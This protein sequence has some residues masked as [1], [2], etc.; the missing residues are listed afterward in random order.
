MKQESKTSAEW[1]A[2]EQ[3]ERI[4]RG[5]LK[6]EPERKKERKNNLSKKSISVMD[7]CSLMQSREDFGCRD[8]AKRNVMLQP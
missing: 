3:Q 8:R 2:K 5:R 1:P 4:F 6:T 7:G